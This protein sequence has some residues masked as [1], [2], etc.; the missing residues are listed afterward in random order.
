MTVRIKILAISG[1]LLVLFAI[2]LIASVVMQRHS[3][4]KLAVIMDFHLP[5]TAA[6]SDLDVATYC[7]PAFP[8][9]STVW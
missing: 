1:V 9:S 6:I 3:S 4:D 5:V 7:V 2:V 8:V